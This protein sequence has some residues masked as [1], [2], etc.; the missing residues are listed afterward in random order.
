M[1]R[2]WRISVRQLPDEVGYARWLCAIVAAVLLAGTRSAAADELRPYTA[3]YN[4]IWKGMTVA[5]STLKLEQTGDT[6]KF[7]SSS[8]PRGLGRMA[9]GVFPP[10]QVSVV[11]VTNQGV[12]PQSFKSSGGDPG[13]SIELNYDWQTHRVRGIYE[14]TMVDLPLTPQVQDDGSVQLGL[15][16]ELLAGRTP[17]TVQLI[18]KNSVREYDFSRDGEETIQTPIGD[19][20][21]V[22][23]KSQKKYSPRI[24]RFW[25]APD[26]G[27]VP[28]KV[29]QKKG[30]DVQWTLEIQSLTRQ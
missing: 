4:G 9:S 19:V 21:T 11:R 29:Q 18:D 14:G 5:V 1:H 15:M 22:I 23:F 28:M 24:T 25:C 6:W 3:T 2:W 26:R 17:P 20:H 10:L 7:S 27:Y 8:E 30:D 16:V 13:N 12:Q